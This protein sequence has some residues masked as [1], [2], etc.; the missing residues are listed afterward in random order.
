MSD[1]KAAR[2]PLCGFEFEGSEGVSC[3][4][5]GW[6]GSCTLV[7]CPACSYEFPAEGYPV[8]RLFRWI[9]GLFRPRASGEPPKHASTERPGSLESFSGVARGPELLEARRRRLMEWVVTEFVDVPDLARDWEAIV[10]AGGDGSASGGAEE[11]AKSLDALCRRLGHP[12]YCPHGKP[13][14]VGACCLRVSDSENRPLFRT[15]RELKPGEV[16]RL[17]YVSPRRPAHFYR[18]SN[19]GFTPGAILVLQQEH[20][21]R[22]VRMSRGQVAMDDEVAECILVRPLGG[23][24]GATEQEKSS[25]GASAT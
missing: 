7:R 22:V 18:L 1:Q 21:V 6:R 19:M 25:A 2:C 3:A 12:R 13:I 15:V 5:C 20:P 4:G 14:P 9:A 23:R 11:R 17:L 24:D 10:T 16:A 8:S